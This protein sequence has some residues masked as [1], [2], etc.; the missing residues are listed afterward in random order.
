[1]ISLLVQVVNLRD[2]PIVLKV[3]T[4][5]F[6]CLYKVCSFS[7]LLFNAET[8]QLLDPCN[9]KESVST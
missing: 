4:E 5:L 6:G 1:M 7:V 2:A 9:Y 3:L 8:S